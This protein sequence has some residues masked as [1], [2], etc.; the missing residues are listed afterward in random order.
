LR[1]VYIAAGAGGMY[2]GACARDVNLVRGLSARSHDVEVI[3]LYTPLRADEESPLSSAPIFYGGINV[4]LQQ[5][6]SIFRHTPGFLKRALDK[7]GP[8][9]YVSKFAI[10]TRAEDLGPMTISV[11]D[12]RNG[13]QRQELDQLLNYLETT[14]PASVINITNSLLSGIAPEIKARL[15]VPVV[16]TLQ[17]EDGF[18]NMMPEPYKSKARELM[19]ENSRSIDA[20]ISPGIRYAERMADFL[21]VPIEKIHVVRAGIHVDTYL[22]QNPRPQT[23]FTIGY[24]SSITR[25]KGLDLLIDALAELINVQGRDV[26][27]KIAGRILDPDFYTKT[28]KSKITRAGLETRVRYAGEV[29]LAGKIAF[30]RDC[31]VFCLPSRIEESRGMAVME[32]MASGL[33]VA[34]PDTGV[35]PEMIE[36]TGGGVTFPSGNVSALAGEIAQLMDNPGQTEPMGKAAAAGIAEHYNAEKMAEETLAVYGRLAE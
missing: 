33:P 25:A 10:R 13:R 4:Y 14:A 18:V 24:L 36:L 11:L 32:A 15:R 23:P 26:H 28:I 5:I 17:G 7:R 16:C 8:L 22:N 31:S 3:A 27:L 34:V 35:F 29:D 30:L 21:S 12:G 19:A 9:N 6:S 20:F 2:C 1:L